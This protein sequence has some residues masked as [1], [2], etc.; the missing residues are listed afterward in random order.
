MGHKE[1]NQTNKQT[2]RKNP[3]S[4]FLFLFSLKFHNIYLRKKKKEETFNYMSCFFS[5]ALL[6]QDNHIMRKPHNN[7]LQP[8]QKVMQFKTFY[9]ENL[10][11]VLINLLDKL[12][13]RDK[14]R[15]LSSILSLFRDESNKFNNTGAWMLFFLSCDI[16][17]ILKSCFWHENFRVLPYAWR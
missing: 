5:P 2:L 13:K 1:S 4:I 16:K 3:V 11:S 7:T 6:W 17:I 10:T 8:A 15:G 9:I 14:M 12:R